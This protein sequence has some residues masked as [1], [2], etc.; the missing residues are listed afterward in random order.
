M[1]LEYKNTY[2]HLDISKTND[3][4][5][6]CDDDYWCN[7]IFNFKNDEINFKSQNKSLSK[8]E[9]NNTI[10]KIKEFYQKNISVKNIKF[11]KNFVKIKIY[12]KNK[13]E[14]LKLTIIKINNQNNNNYDIILKNNEI[15]KMIKQIEK[16]EF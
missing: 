15:S 6:L 14:F 8:K 5:G 11:I 2:Y 1:N 10:I 9:I 7:I 13:D 3:I 16:M 4:T 12:K